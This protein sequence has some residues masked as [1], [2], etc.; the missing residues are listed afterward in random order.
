LPSSFIV[1]FWCGPP[2]T[3]FDDARAEEI[4]A[5]GFTIVG[6]PCEAA[7]DAEHNRRALD[8]AARHGLRM[9]IADPRFAEDAA[10]HPGWLAAVGAA[11][12][13]YRD[14]PALAGYFVTDEPLPDRFDDLA[15]IL[16]AL[17]AA[18]PQRLAY[19]NLLADYSISGSAPNPYREY[20]ERFIDVVHPSLLS[21]DY[22][23]FAQTRDRQ[24][25]FSSL[26]LIR[27]EAL[28]HDLPFMLIVQAMPHAAYRD[29]TEAELSW[30][31]FH[32]LAYGARGVSYF[33][34]WT[35]RD[36]AGAAAFNFRDGLID[37][38]QP[39]RHYFEATR[40]N[41]VLRAMAGELAPFHS[42]AV[43]DSRG[44][45]ASAL[46]LG[47]I[48]KIDGPPVTA[49]L[50]ADAAGRRAM[51]LVN[52]DYRHAGR[53]HL[54]LVS[55]AARPDRFDAATRTWISGQTT[56]KMPAGGAVL[57]RWE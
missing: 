16:A 23:P 51:L 41:P 35:P 34:Y 27:D 22:Y 28:T 11:V 4:A 5:A 12:A 20:V 43:G 30:Q 14:H 17:R 9:W 57:L 7:H 49:G 1:T 15:Q 42:V 50:F 13:D 56:V 39:T 54:H 32:A 48:A 36:A 21:Y 8:I 10:G 52:R 55:G 2:L 53:A 19:V 18:D 44:G 6:P 33:A 40:L 26:A 29:P 31:L 3:E 45:V 37:S 24:T 38:G 25:F 46:P 47:P